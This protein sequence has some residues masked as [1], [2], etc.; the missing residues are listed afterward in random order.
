[1]NPNERIIKKMVK[2]AYECLGQCKDCA[3]L[4][5][6]RLGQKWLKEKQK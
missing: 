6:C 4:G 1:M 5:I 3:M 2:E